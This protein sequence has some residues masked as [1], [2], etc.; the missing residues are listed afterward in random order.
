M[1]KRVL[2]L[3]TTHYTIYEMII[4]NLVN[5]G[6]EVIHFEPLLKEFKYKNIFQKVDNFFRKT[7]LNDKDYKKKLQ[8]KHLENQLNEVLNFPDNYFDI[9]LAIRPDAYT[10]TVINYIKKISKKTIAYQWDGMQR[11]KTNENI[12]TYF[13]SFGVF[14]P[15]DYKKYYLYKNVFLTNNFFFD[16]LPIPKKEIDILYIGA[17]QEN[18]KKI[19]NNISLVSNQSNL[20]KYLRIYT[21][22]KKSYQNNSYI[23]NSEKL[24]YS[25]FIYFSSKAKCII[26]IKVSTHKGLSLRFF[27]ALHFKQKIITNNT[28]VKEF[29]FFNTNNILV[30][31]DW[32]KI[33]PELLLNFINTP[34]EPISNEIILKYSFENWFLSLTSNNE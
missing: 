7:F 13:D 16:Y 3:M 17:E 19:I 2:L 20:T 1:K 18:R 32:F 27:E 25:D 4:Q 31:E 34:L 28:Y 12:I 26:D 5:M 24:S 6:Y 23:L 14:D 10:T 33:T 9:S 29:D 15:D 21:E 8:N 11:Y 22:K 30:I